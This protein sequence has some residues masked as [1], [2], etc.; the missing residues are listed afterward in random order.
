ML[1]FIVRDGEAMMIEIAPRVG[2]D[3]LPFLIR[4]SCGLDIF[5]CALDF[6]A[7]ATTPIPTPE[8][9]RPLV[10]LRLFA[11]EGG[12]VR[13]I[14]DSRLRSDAR[15]LE[16][17]LLRRPGDAIVLPPDDYGSWLLGHVILNF[18]ES[19]DIEALHA[20]LRAQLRITMEA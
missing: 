3:C 2:G 18:P 15:V 19:G 20:E 10:G 1:D 13:T 17:M 11:D 4:Q 9:W 8:R 12:T 14:D 5:G 16:Y 6:A 7:G